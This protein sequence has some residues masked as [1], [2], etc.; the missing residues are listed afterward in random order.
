MVEQPLANGIRVEIQARIL[1]LGSVGY[2]SEVPLRIVA[3]HS[4]TGATALHV[5][6][7]ALRAEPSTRGVEITFPAPGAPLVD[8]LRASGPG[9]R[10]LCLWSY[11]SAEAE[12]VR[13]E[14]ARAREATVGLEVLHVAGGVHATAEP[15][16]TLSDGF[17]AVAV[18]EGER[19]LIEAVRALEAGGALSG[20]RGLGV[21]GFGGAM[22]GGAPAERVALDD[23]PAFNIP[24]SKFN[25]IEITRGCIYA[26]RFCQTPF[27]FKARF[28]HRSVASISEHVR[29]MRHRRLRFARF[30]SPTAL[31]YGADGTEPNLDAVEELLARVREDIGPEGKV[32]FGTF[33]S[34]VRPEH[35]TDR[36]LAMMKKYV[37]NDNLVIGG[38]SGSLRVLE[39][40]KRGH[41][42]ESVVRA[43]E[44]AARHGFRANVD[45]LFGLPGEDDADQRATVALMRRLVAL[46]AR[47]HAHTFMPLPGTPLA[48]APAGTVLPALEREL[49]KL[50]AAGKSYGQWRSQLVAAERLAQRRSGPG[51]SA[52]DG[53][54]IKEPE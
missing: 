35:V 20:V 26:C 44:I 51:A 37:D 34:E 7:A 9:Q 28:R 4:K 40:S 46:G 10:T 2:G 12:A 3:R 19:T 38:Q 21:S 42:V 43:A 36:A 32:F 15:A 29:F 11:Y 49:G 31:S 48:S 54:L 30:I 24:D 16:R 6:T 18:G 25:P 47:V 27:A 52:P 17:D 50:E 33:P 41:D 8:A 39:E 45:M 23:Y 5:L 14:L 53:G 22:S 1:P 13:D